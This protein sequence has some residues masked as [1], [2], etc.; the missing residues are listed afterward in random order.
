MIRTS[1][2]PR[3]STLAAILSTVVGA[4][5]ASPAQETRPSP[6]ATTS[7][8]TNP[9]EA[10]DETTGKAIGNAAAAA[11]NAPNFAATE[12]YEV[13]DL[14]GW[15]VRVSPDLAASPGLRD[16][17][18]ELLDNQLF[19][20]VRVVPAPALERLRR[21]EIW[22]ETEMPRTACMCYHVSKGWLVP[23]GYN[24]DKE[25]AVEIGNAVAFLRWTRHQPWMVLHELAHAYH[26]QVLGYRHAGIEA[27]WRRIAETGAYDEVGHIAGGTRRHY[28]LTNPMEYFAETTEALF[29]TNDFHPYVRSELEAV[30]PEGFAL[31]ASLWALDPVPEGPEDAEATL[32]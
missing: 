2:P 13:R 28:A 17:V 27:A 18:L 26:D 4:A 9:R 11:A 14:R 31:V 15:T 20:I 5:F 1:Q 8:Q 3:P 6:P 19:R 12:A 32:R 24:P 23:N 30:D 29:G 22:A 25:G 10:S 7:R 16:A 21:V